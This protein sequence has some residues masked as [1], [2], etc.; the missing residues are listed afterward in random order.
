MVAAGLERDKQRRPAG[1]IPGSLER[2]DLGVWSA[3]RRMPAFA[4]DP[5]VAG[6]I[7]MRHHRAHHRIG[8]NPPLT[9]A[10]QLEGPRHRNG[11]MRIKHR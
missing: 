1:A 9:T 6:L 5:L 11:V 3:K 10:G 2:H 8:F 4:D 7:A